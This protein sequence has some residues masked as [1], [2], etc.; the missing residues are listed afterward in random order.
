VQFYYSLDGSTWVSVTT[1]DI[2]AATIG[3]AASAYSFAPQATF[4]VASFNI[5]GLNIATNGDIYLRWNLN[6]T[7]SNSQGIGIDNVNVTATFSAPCIPPTTQAS[8]LTSTSVSCSSVTLDWTRGNGNA[9]LITGIGGSSST[10]SPSSGVA[11]TGNSVFTAGSSVGGGYAVYNG[12]GTSVTITGLAGN[13]QYTFAAYEYATTGTCYKTI[14]VTVTFTTASCG[15]TQCPYITSVLVNSCEGSCAEGDNEVIFFNTG[16]SSLIATPA[17]IQTYYGNTAAPSTN[18]TESFATNAS[19]ISSM[20]TAAG[21]GTLFIDASSGSTIPA[22]SSVMIARSSMCQNAYDWTSLCG[23]GPVYVL[24]ST[25]ASWATGGNFVNG[26]GTRYFRTTY[27]GCVTDYSYDSDLLPGGNGATIVYGTTGGAPAAYFNNGCTLSTI[28]LPVA[29]HDFTAKKQ[30]PAVQ[31]SWTAMNETNISHYGV[32]KSYDG[33][34]YTPVGTVNQGGETTDGNSYTVM[35]EAP[36]KGISYYRLFSM[37]SRGDKKYHKTISF[38]PNDQLP[39][40]Y[41]IAYTDESVLIRVKDLSEGTTIRL[42]SLS[43]CLVYGAS[44]DNNGRLEIG[45]NDLEK[46]MYLV[47]IRNRARTYNDKIIIQ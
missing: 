45:L 35:D 25:D 3:T 7:G 12:T 37:G 24:F 33:I 6:T 42:Y 1:G 14:P 8:S 18:Y 40:A 19:S 11:Y 10:T 28:V 4:S 21:C 31:L 36:Y 9:V 13:T 15:G 32:E 39:S 22:N 16:S 34:S 38:D 27:N 26:G 46:G 29:I 23:H 47:Q 44:S 5:T 41:T 17:N 30:D 2:A 43:G 20:N